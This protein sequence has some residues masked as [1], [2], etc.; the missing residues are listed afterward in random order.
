MA[1]SLTRTAV[2]VALWGIFAW[3]SVGGEPQQKGPQPKEPET[4]P[5]PKAAYPEY[6]LVFP[7]RLDTRNIWSLYAPDRF[8]RMRP[9][10]VLAPY[11]SYYL[12]GGEPYPWT[13]TQQQFLLPRTAD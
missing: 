13:T 4:L 12:R 10:V 5:A 3:T 2:A 1:A 11:G 6:R 8:G 7:P 9:R